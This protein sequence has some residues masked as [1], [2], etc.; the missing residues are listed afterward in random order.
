VGLVFGQ[1]QDWSLGSLLGVGVL[2][3]ALTW[4]LLSRLPR[5]LRAGKIEKKR[6]AQAQLEKDA[7]AWRRHQQADTAAHAARQEADAGDTKQTEQGG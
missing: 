2:L 4:L 3:G 7:K 1:W 6:K 5:I